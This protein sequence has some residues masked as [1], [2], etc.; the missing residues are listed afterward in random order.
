MPTFYVNRFITLISCF[1]FLTEKVD[2]TQ[3]EFYVI[4][5]LTLP[6]PVIRQLSSNN[7]QPTTIYA[8]RLKNEI[9]YP[10]YFV[11]QY[12]KT[13][14]FAPDKPYFRLYLLLRLPA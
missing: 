7:K 3:R 8:L 11:F 6:D 14:R 12:S 4:F 1:N 13:I 5:I 9:E 10:D 2:I